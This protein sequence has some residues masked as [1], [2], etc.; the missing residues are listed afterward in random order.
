MWLSNQHLNAC[1]SLLLSSSW[2]S[3]WPSLRE[4]KPHRPR[5]YLLQLEPIV[6]EFYHD[7]VASFSVYVLNGIFYLFFLKLYE[8][9]GSHPNHLLKI[10]H[11]L[12]DF[13]IFETRQDTKLVLSSNFPRSVLLIGSGQFRSSTAVQDE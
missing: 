2:P 6:G 7:I 3:F 5:R 12:R 9:T 8:S 13:G 4:G 1:R 10:S 11:I